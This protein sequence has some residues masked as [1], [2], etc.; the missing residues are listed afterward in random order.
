MIKTK[1]LKL[2]PLALALSMGLMAAAP[3]HANERESLETL[4][5]T[6]FAS[7]KAGE[8]LNI[9]VDHQTM[10]MVDVVERTLERLMT[11]RI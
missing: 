2:T 10:V 3:A 5:Q 4:R 7:Y 6:T 9:E 11:K 1:H 8:R